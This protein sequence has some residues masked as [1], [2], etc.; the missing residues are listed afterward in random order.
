M[1]MRTAMVVLVLVLSLAACGPNA[2]PPGA[3]QAQGPQL[4]SPAPESEP[5]RVFGPVNDA[6]RTATGDLTV[7][8]SL[9]LPDSSEAGADATD[10]L[11]LSGANGLRVEAQITGALS[12]ATQVQGQTLRALLNIPVEEPTALVYRVTNETKPEGRGGLCGA[13]AAS[14]VVVWEPSTPGDAGMKVLGVMGGAPGAGDSR[15]CP[16]LEYRRN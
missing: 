4:D 14:Y 13:D 11:T 10:V 7:S 5:S 8:L 1:M 2:G 12:P 15:A 3:D 16:M 6:A 9:R